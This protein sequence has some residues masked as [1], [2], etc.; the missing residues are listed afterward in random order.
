MA[1]CHN[2]G[3]DCPA[4]NNALK[5]ANTDCPAAPKKDEEESQVHPV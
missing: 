4:G 5:C 2:I 1:Y 3:G